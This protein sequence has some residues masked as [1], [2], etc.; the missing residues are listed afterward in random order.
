[1]RNQRSH[2]SLRG[3]H[4]GLHG[5][6]VERIRERHLEHCTLDADRQRD[7]RTR[8]V[9][10][11]ERDRLGIDAL[12]Q[13]ADLRVELTGNG[14]GEGFL[15]DEECVDSIHRIDR[16]IVR[17]RNTQACQQPR[18]ISVDWSA[19]VVHAHRLRDGD[20]AK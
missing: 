9:F 20:F 2:R 11:E 18:N 16:S 17:Q 1:M 12:L 4:H 19:L 6:R 5:A 14:I 10:R 7:A 15:G 8:D 13:V 3:I